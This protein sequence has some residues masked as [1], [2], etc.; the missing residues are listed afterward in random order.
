MLHEKRT[1]NVVTANSAEE[2]A[3][4]LTEHSWTSCQA[5][6]LR[7]YLFANDATCA[8]GAQEY[9]VLRQGPV[10]EELI[11]IE[12]ITFSW[13]SPAKAFWLIQRI[14]TGEF[15]AGDYSRVCVARFQTPTEHCFC[16]LCR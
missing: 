3:E 11:Q 16:Q 14:L 4:L 1:W 15:D 8:D 10:N 12:S 5:F 9:A 7:G 6:E 2:L 13:C